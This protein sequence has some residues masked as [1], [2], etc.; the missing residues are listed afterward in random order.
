MEKPKNIHEGHRKRLL[1][2]L[3]ANVDNISEI[4]L[5]E[6][7][8]TFYIPRKDTNPL[9]HALLDEFGSFANVLDADC[10]DL[11][12]VKGIGE[13]TAKN[14]SLLKGIFTR[15]RMDKYKSK[16]KIVTYGD[17]QSYFRDLL[18][19][20]NEEEFHLVCLNAKGEIA[21]TKLLQRGDVN[22][23]H[24]SIRTVSEFAIRCRAVNVVMGHCHPD[25]DATPSMADLDT[26]SAI[27]TALAAF[28]IEVLDHVI[29]GKT[30]EDL[31][32]MAQDGI[33][34]NLKNAAAKVR[35]GSLSRRR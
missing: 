22:H 18:F 4:N 15:Y 7:V 21:G 9:A 10:L 8:L 35:E 34:Q 17:C 12:K 31:F 14:I 24:F 3:S 29:V 16:K 32:S 25:A 6:Y 33:L 28:Q 13:T 27:L 2:N 5:L 1:T 26:T 23:I 19:G 30:E 11:M 20:K